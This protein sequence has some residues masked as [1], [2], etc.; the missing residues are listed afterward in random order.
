[1]PLKSFTQIVETVITHPKIADGIYVDNSGNVFTTSGGLAS[2]TEIGKYDISTNNFNPDFAVGFSG[3]INIAPYRDSLYIVSNYDNSTVYAYNLNSNQ[4]DTIALGLDEPAGIIIDA[5]EN[6]FVTNWGQAPA[7][8]GHQIH[9]ISSS[10]YVSNYADSL[11]LYRPQGITINHLGELI[12]HSEQRLYKVN[13]SDS[14]LSLWV[15]VGHYIGNMVFRKKY[16]CIYG[17]SNQGH[18][19]IKIDHLGDVSIFSGSELGYLDGEI[20]SALFER[21]IGV[22]FSK[23]EDTLY[24]SE[25][26]GA[27]RLRR[28][29]MNETVTVPSNKTQNVVGIYPNPSNGTYI[30]KVKDKNEISVEVYS[31]SGELIFFQT[32]FNIETYLDLS[33]FPKGNYMIKLS[34][35]NQIIT[36]KIIKI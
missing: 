26:L 8:A 36:K 11:I 30:I 3:P 21:P 33:K 27:N 32:K 25:G 12:V 22:A 15:I 24:I 29:I 17:A 34:D 2:G 1:M 28:V 19:I 9:K 31:S 6:I 13:P 16:S 35:E 14:S 5:N 23:S 7:W 20:G 10:G 4:I 18:K